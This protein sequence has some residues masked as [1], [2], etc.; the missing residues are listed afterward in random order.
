MGAGYALGD[1]D[2][3]PITTFVARDG[4]LLAT[5]RAEPQAESLLQLLQKARVRARDGRYVNLLAFVDC[6]V[7]FYILSKW[8]RADFYTE[9][10]EV[11]NFDVFRPLLLGLRQWS[12]NVLLV[13]I[14]SHTGCLV[15]E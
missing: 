1:D 4:G 13:K 7:V 2:P 6:L 8:G 11:V 15:N 14:K 5:T 10:K 3:E 9:H 12:G